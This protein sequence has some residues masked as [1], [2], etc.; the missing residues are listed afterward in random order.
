MEGLFFLCGLVGIVWLAYWTTQE[1]QEKTRSRP[2]W[3]PFDW[4][5]EPPPKVPPP[6]N[7]TPRAEDWRRR[8][9]KTTP[10]TITT[11]RDR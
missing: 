11:T 10:R 5:D 7:R 9:I 1:G 8:T 4:Q 2:I 6:D 3:S